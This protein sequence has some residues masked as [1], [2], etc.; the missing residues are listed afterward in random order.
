SATKLK[1]IGTREMQ[2]E[3]AVRLAELDKEQKVGEQ[4]AGFERDAR[5]KE[6]EQKMRISLA[7]ANAKAVAGENMAEAAVVASKAALQVKQAE[8]YQLAETKKREA[9]ALVLEA[10]N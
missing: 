10:Q 7:D 2:R 3:Q 1:Q 4:T 6:A 9:E 8:A 5:V